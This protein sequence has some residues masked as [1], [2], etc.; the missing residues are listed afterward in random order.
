M[1]VE[2]RRCSYHVAM[3]IGTAMCYIAFWGASSPASAGHPEDTFQRSCSMIEQVG[4]SLSAICKDRG[5]TRIQTSLHDIH[6]CVGGI[7]NQD[8][9][10]TCSRSEGVPQGSYLQSCV[11]PVVKGTTLYSR[12]KRKNGQ[13]MATQLANYANCNQGINN[14]DGTLQCG[15]P[16]SASGGGASIDPWSQC[17]VVTEWVYC[18]RC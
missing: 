4:N 15:V 14:N 11:E 5:G 13:W 16:A 17:H 3:L 2:S 18:M 8:G 6:T 12:C 7:H 9:H 10:L 1:R